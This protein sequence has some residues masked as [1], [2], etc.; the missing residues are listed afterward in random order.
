MLHP[1]I[2]TM[3][4]GLVYYS[5]M[6]GDPR[7]L[8]AVRDQIV[9]ASDG[10]PLVSVTLAPLDFGMN[11][12]P[13]LCA[14]GRDYLSLVYPFTCSH[15]GRTPQV[16][17]RGHLTMF[18]QILAGLQ[19]LDT[20]LACL[21][22]HDVLYAPEHFQFVPPDRARFWYNQHRWQVSAVDG[23][24][25]HYRCCQTSGLCA[26]RQLLIAHYRARVARVERDGFSR[27]LG[28][29]PGTNSRSRSIDGVGFG[30]WFSTRPNLDIRH[31]KNLTLTRWSPEVF[32]NKNSCLGWT[33]A[34]PEG[35][36]G[37]GVTAGRF[38]QFLSDLNRLHIE[39]VQPQG[40]SS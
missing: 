39:V 2:R 8:Q 5:D 15:C 7:L 14:C 10:L 35:I 17:E 25:V 38:D 13:Y 23:R 40:V 22:E 34:G 36:P 9:R 11:L 1:L 20:D 12:V 24:A 31:G 4:K 21:V 29:E 26:D 30:T 28:F 32:R 18:K 33:E 3:T 6:R 19:L 16:F 27:A 37:W